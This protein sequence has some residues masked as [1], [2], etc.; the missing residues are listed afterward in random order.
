MGNHGS[1]LDGRGNLRVGAAPFT[2]RL[3][4]PKK[5]SGGV[6]GLLTSGLHK[7]FTI[8]WV[9][10]ITGTQFFLEN[11]CSIISCKKTLHLDLR[12]DK[13]HLALYSIITVM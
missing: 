6:F 10:K 12:T 13:A 4:A 8:L 5:S 2:P 11:E 7:K 3:I 1:Y 9:K